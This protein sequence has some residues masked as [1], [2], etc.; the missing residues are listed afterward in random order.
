[1]VNYQTH[2]WRLK[3]WVHWSHHLTWPEAAF[4]PHSWVQ[5]Y[6]VTVCLDLW[7]P[8]S[9]PLSMLSP[10][11]FSAVRVWELPFPQFLFLSEVWLIASLCNVLSS[12][13]LPETL[14]TCS[15]ISIVISGKFP[16]HKGPLLP[17][18]MPKGKQI[19][20]KHQSLCVSNYTSQ[21]EPQNKRQNPFVAQRTFS[22]GGL[23]SLVPWQR[24]TLSGHSL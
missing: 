19:R 7:P 24:L 17:F 20:E 9:Y 5:A 11:C 1:M 8:L 2:A 3:T 14:C 22:P 21:M 13:N 4:L 16:I 23:G 15:V 10:I 18:F 12:L 6:C